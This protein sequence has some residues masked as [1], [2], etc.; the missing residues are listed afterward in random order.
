MRKIPGKNVHNTKVRLKSIARNWNEGKTIIFVS[1]KTSKWQNKRRNVLKIYMMLAYKKL[2]DDL[3]LKQK[4]YTLM[5]T[6]HPRI[7]SNSNNETLTQK[8]K[9]QQKISPMKLLSWR[10]FGACFQINCLHRWYD[11]EILNHNAIMPVF[12]SLSY[13]LLDTRVW[14]LVVGVHCFFLI[15]IFRC[16]ALSQNPH[17]TLV[18]WKIVWLIFSQLMK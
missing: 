13:Y 4:K 5:A 14:V 2:I 8:T 18:A 6:Q 7:Q 17:W 11:Y 9:Q 15:I 16:K 12:S 3:Q 10:K 1:T